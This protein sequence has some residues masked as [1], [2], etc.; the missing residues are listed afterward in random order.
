MMADAPKPVTLAD[1]DRESKVA[2]VYC[3]A[4][5][6]ER[7]VPAASLGLPMN[8]SVPAAG[9]RLI[10]SACGGRNVSVKPEL[11]PRGRRG[12]AEEAPG[13]LMRVLTATLSQAGCKAGNRALVGGAFVPSIQDSEIVAAWLVVGHRAP[14][15]TA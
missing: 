15:I 11:Y 9:K 12:D 4:C 13:M 14:A 6:R 3:N 10:C 2:R 8:T 5:G 7:D 1:I